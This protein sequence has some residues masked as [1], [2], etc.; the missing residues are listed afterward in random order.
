MSA[1]N[2]T[3]VRQIIDRAYNG[4]DLT[5]LG[6]VIGPGYIAH[7]PGFERR[8]VEGIREH[9][10]SDHIGWPDGVITIDDQVAEGDKMVTSWSWRGTHTGGNKPTDEYSTV[11]SVIISRIAEGKVVEE[12]WYWDMPGWLEQ[13]GFATRVE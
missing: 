3:L 10:A 1:E 7:F 2:K 4:K 9:F 6:E 5:M 13:L 8:E 12:W 11:S